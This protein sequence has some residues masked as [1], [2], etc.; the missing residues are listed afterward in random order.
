MAH[1]NRIAQKH[2]FVSEPWIPKKQELM[3]KMEIARVPPNSR[4]DGHAVILLIG[5]IV[6]KAKAARVK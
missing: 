2:P 1:G 6:S 4:D 3:D 5:P